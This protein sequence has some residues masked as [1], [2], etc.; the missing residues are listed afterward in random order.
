MKLYDVLDDIDFEDIDICDDTYDM[1]VAY[2]MNPEL[3]DDGND[4]DQLLVKI[5]K[6]LDVLNV[7]ENLIV[8][9]I[10]KWIK[11][12]FKILDDIFDVGGI[13]E[14]DELEELVC[15]V[16]PGIVAGYT[17]DSVYKELNDKIK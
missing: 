9:D 1:C 10:T 14:E 7:S 12:N 11:D 15:T 3:G 6:S 4:Y 5:A 16:F 2:C 17:T 8:C 13:N